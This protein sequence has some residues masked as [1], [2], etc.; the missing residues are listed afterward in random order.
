MPLLA[1]LA[2]FTA[3]ELIG[4]PALDIRGVNTL[5]EA[6][7]SDLSFLANPLYTEAMKKSGAG[8]VCIAKNAPRPAGKSFLVSENPSTTFQKIA[9]LL[10]R[11]GEKSAWDHIH[12]TAVVHPSVQL[13]EGVVIGPYA[14]ID[15]NTKIGAHTIIGPHVVIS[16][17]VTIGEACYFHP[18][19][20]VRERCV[21]GN[22][23]ILQPGA[24][25]GS[26]GFGYTQDEQGRHI[27]LEQLGIVILE[28]DVEIGANTT[29][30]RSRFKATI[31][32]KGSKIDNLC[33]IAHNVEIGQHNV[34]AAQV[35]IAGS[36]KTGNY[37][38][39]GG[40]VGVLGHVELDDFVMIASKGGVSKSLKK[41]KYRGVPAIP[42]NDY[43]RQEVHVRKLEEYV[44]RLKELERKVGILEKS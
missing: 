7:S 2:A 3:A 23:I 21:L 42:I 36:S 35:G 22:R 24:V 32:R 20:T 10:L 5:D 40:Q 19:V 37:V 18:H 25:I 39:M 4:D 38:M 26:C 8:A 15:R 27:K 12:P 16:Y 1:E 33:Q 34:L 6:T 9:E 29:I 44:E 11:S 28:D 14:V 31:V 17:G 41:G 13:G 30:D 43:N